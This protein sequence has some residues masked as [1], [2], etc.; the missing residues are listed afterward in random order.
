MPAE[1]KALLL[2]LS[3]VAL[4]S[5]VATGFKLGLAVMAP[6]QLLLHT[7]SQNLGFPSIGSWLMYGLGTENENLPGFIV[8]VSGGNKP[9][10]N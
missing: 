6:A 5:T 3:A 9:G 10:E 4:W 7:G 1:R 8:L 2:A